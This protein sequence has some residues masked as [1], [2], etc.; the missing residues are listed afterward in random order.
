[1]RLKIIEGNPDKIKFV[2]DRSGET[3]TIDEKYVKDNLGNLV[4]DTD[5][6]KFIL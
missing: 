2:T 5:L 4:K 1:V 3:I 6:S